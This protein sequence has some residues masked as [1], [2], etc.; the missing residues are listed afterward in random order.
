MLTRLPL[1]NARGGRCRRAIFDPCTGASGGPFL[2]EGLLAV[3]ARRRPNPQ[4]ALPRHRCSPLV[5]GVGKGSSPNGVR[6]R[7]APIL[8][9]KEDRPPPQRWTRASRSIYSLPPT[10]V[11]AARFDSARPRRRRRSATSISAFPRWSA[12]AAPPTDG[13]FPNDVQEHLGLKILY[14]RRPEIRN[15]PCKDWIPPG[16]LRCFLKSILSRLW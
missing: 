2:E 4:A 7:R 3:R 9:A 5:S 8:V 1:S 12:I 14:L 10:D 6:A 15:A 16:A 13:P 11:E